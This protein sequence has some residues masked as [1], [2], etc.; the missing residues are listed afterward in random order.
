MK[1]KIWENVINAPPTVLDK[2]FS[3]RLTRTY[4]MNRIKFPINAKEVK[5]VIVKA[6][7]NV[8]FIFKL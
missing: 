7:Q 2:T 8:R 3:I 5:I 6:N 4:I 1:T